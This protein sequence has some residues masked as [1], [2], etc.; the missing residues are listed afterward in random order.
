MW[1]GWRT[2]GMWR[3]RRSSDTVKIIE[4]HTHGAFGYRVHQVLTALGALLAE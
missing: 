4:V 2:E 3:S 1:S